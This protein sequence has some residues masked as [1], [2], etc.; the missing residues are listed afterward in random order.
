MKKQLITKNMTV[1]EVINKYPRAV[2]VFIEYGLHC[3]GCPAAADE[4]IEQAVK[5]HHIDLK[6]LLKDLNKITEVKK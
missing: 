3:L 5:F 2:F 4:T 1:K 6:K